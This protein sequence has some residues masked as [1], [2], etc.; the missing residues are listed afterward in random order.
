MEGTCP[1]DGSSPV[2][3]GNGLNNSTPNP[4]ANNNAVTSV[5]SSNRIHNSNDNAAT[6]LPITPK[7]EHS[8]PEHFERQTVLMYGN[9]S[10]N[11]NQV[12][13]R[14]PTA[15][16]TTN[17]LYTD[18][19][20]HHLKLSNQIVTS[21]AID[22][23]HPNSHIKWNDGGKE[24]PSSGISVY[25]VHAH[26]DAADVDAS[27]M[28]AVQVQSQATHHSGHGIV[29]PEHSVH[30]LPSQNSHQTVLQSASA[31]HHQSV[32]SSCE[33]WSPAYSQYQYF[34]YHHAPQ[35]AST[36]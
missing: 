5:N 16:P 11:S 13:N 14:S 34:T 36:Q 18:S 20:Q 2:N 24:H 4:N 25:Q 9:A 32:G 19:Q 7:V 3:N 22:D 10:T 29:S 17:N 33:V 8:P 23:H 31:S 6:V 35:H 27:A 1:S 15:T 28:Y 30:H 12:T 21:P 26:Q